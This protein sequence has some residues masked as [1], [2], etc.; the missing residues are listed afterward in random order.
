M[1]KRQTEIIQ[2]LGK[3]DGYTTFSKLAKIM[4]VSVKTIR[5]DAA[6]ISEYLKRH[7]GGMLETKPHSGIR[8]TPDEDGKDAFFEA[9]DKSERDVLF[10]IIN[11]LLKNKSLTATELSRK[12]YLGKAETDKILERA[13]IWFA[14]NNIEF[15]RRRGKGIT[16]SFSEFEYRVA[17]M[18][19]FRE[20]K[21]LWAKRITKSSPSG[22]LMTDEE[23]TALCASLEGF[24]P[25]RAE[26]A[27]LKTSEDF[28][29][30][31]GDD[32]SVNL[33]FLTSICVVRSCAGFNLKPT[34]IKKS[35]FG[36]SSGEKVA[37]V[38]SKRL[39]SAYGAAL[40]E[41][42]KRFL[43]FAVD[44]SEIRS[45][46]SDDA[47]RHFENMNVKL[48]G[49]TVRCV[50]LI[51]EI[52]ETRLRCDR[53]FVMQMFLFLKASEAR[54]RFG[55]VYKN[56]L[57]SQIKESYPNMMAL[58]WFLEN[59]FENELNLRINEHEVGFLALLIGGAL[60]RQR[61]VFSACLIC[62][63]GCGVSE[64][65]KERIERAVPEIKIV[66]LISGQDIRKI[67]EGDFDFIISASP[68]ATH[69]S[70]KAEIKVSH[71]LNEND[72]KRLKEHISRFK[73]KN[74]NSVKE[75]EP[76]E[77]LFCKDLIFPYSNFRTKEEIIEKM[78][79][80]LENLGYVTQGFKESVLAREN[81]SPTG[82]G[83]GFAI[84]HGL[85][86]FVNHSAVA[87]MSLSNPIWWE[88]GGECVDM[89]F[90]LAFDMDK[91]EQVKRYA[92][93]FYKS[94]VAFMD[95]EKECE[96]LKKADNAD[97]IL[98]MLKKW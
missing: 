67:N 23:Y 47:R 24:N 10:F 26:E 8:F 1:N 54:L 51:S 42:E 11:H 30:C 17:K 39:E 98:K 90:L 32:S 96:R 41:D 97:E 92:A 28:G 87:F 55:I 13:R 37:A 19:F 72:I 5:N 22:I 95:D 52:A 64:I 14:E 9:E 49:F 61:V 79:V 48:C 50:N 7:G 75:I 53:L 36:G 43:A 71:L 76:S 83:R 84:P 93:R 59:T 16:V 33:L 20:Y 62:G 77:N 44:I 63:N 82:I 46:K 65:L 86:S 45:F 88:S 89:I 18:R 4:G 60:S 74:R 58:A 35:E 6:A 40:S 2:L 25:R 70:L 68:L 81:S 31:F 21:E 78:C 34:Q 29:V 94:L 15:N 66:S 57:L 73:Q 38:L 91:D 12:Y 80:R 69:F 27:I 85:G 56:P 3:S